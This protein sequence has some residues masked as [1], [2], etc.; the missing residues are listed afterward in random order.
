[1]SKRL[2]ITADDFGADL[3]VN[4]AVEHAHRHGILS[5]A[6]LMVTAPAA[7]D[8][9]ARA[10]S[11]PSLGVGLHVVLVDGRPCLPPE[12]IPALVGPD[13]AFAPNMV[14]TALRIA[15]C[16]KARA[17]MRAEVC[18]Q[19]A[20]FA[21]TGLALDHANAHKHFHLHP[22]IAHAIIAAGKPHGLPA[23][24]CPAQGRGMLALWARVLA[25]GWRRAG[26]R[27]NHR[28]EGLAQSGRFDTAAMVKAL[29]R[30][31]PGLTEIYT[32]PATGPYPD[33]AP[34][35]A[36]AAELSALTAP[37]TREALLR[38]GAILGP[39]RP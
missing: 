8:A 4:E 20:A 17:Q 30:L 16:P 37:Q 21:K 2:V 5:A 29:S 9:V 27:V 31:R 36:Y 11:L 7:D 13:G 14:R 24:R 25:V 1:V 12:Q 34:F 35:Y 39:F 38:S 22:M 15:F 23:L 26:L 28:V 6:S 32:H 10:Q 18:A 19:F 33:G 3:A